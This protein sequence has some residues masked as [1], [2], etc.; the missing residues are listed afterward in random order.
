L[1]CLRE[2]RRS[3]AD[4]P[5]IGLLQES[6]F[7]KVLRFWKALFLNGLLEQGSVGFGVTMWDEN[8]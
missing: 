8:T 2:V 3:R 7:S 6:S 1:N 5:T 4:N